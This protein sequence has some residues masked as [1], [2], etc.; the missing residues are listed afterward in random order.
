MTESGA[1]IAEDFWGD[2][3][4]VDV[5]VRSGALNERFIMPPFTILD[6][7]QGY[8]QERKRMWAM[9]GMQSELGRAAHNMAI[10][11]EHIGEQYGRKSRDS[12]SIFDPV[13]C[14]LMY[15]WFC[16]PGGKVLDPFAG[17]SVRGIVASKLGYFYT[18]VELR[19]EQVNADIDQGKT[20]LASTVPAA[21]WLCGDALQVQ[22]L[23]PGEYDFILTCPPYGDV[24]VYSDDPRD[25]STMPYA[26]FIANYRLIIER[27]CSMLRN[28]RFACMVVSNF[29]SSNEEYLHDFVGDT[30]T[31]FRRCG[32][33]LLN[34][35]ILINTCG[36]L[37]IRA[38]RGFNR[39]RKLGR[40]HQT[41][42]VFCKGDAYT[43]AQ[44][45][46]IV[47]TGFKF[48]EEQQREW[49]IEDDITD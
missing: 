5:Y 16:T 15:K 29:R 47:D 23:A 14:E 49:G 1:I 48:S 17:G 28:D 27:S 40:T 13:L 42:L 21:R 38:S 10:E 45:C 24:E 46:G 19:Q 12:V 39:S 18:G 31:A 8:W 7:R 32:L 26:R 22:Q 33:E 36:T 3:H 4:I 34:E 20:I 6:T 11:A 30:I 44:Q 25:L 2:K 9:L 43:A 41:V 35:A 37:P